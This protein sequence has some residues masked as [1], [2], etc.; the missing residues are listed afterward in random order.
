MLHK[1][2]FVAL[3]CGA[4]CLVGCLKNEESPSVTQVRNAKANELNA[5]AKLLEAQAAAQTTLAAAEAKLKEAQAELAKAN[6]ALVKAQAQYEEV[7]AELLGVEVKLQMVK[8]DEEKVELQ[9]KQA[10][11]EIL[12]AQVEAAK[13]EAEAEVQRWVNELNQLK[14]AAEVQAINAQLQ[15][16]EAQ[17]AM[18]EFMAKAEADKAA[19]MRPYIETYFGICEG[20]VELQKQAINMEIEINNY[21]NG[22]YDVLDGMEEELN[23]LA[24]QYN[25]AQATLEYVSQYQTMTPEEKEAAAAEAYDALNE[26]ITAWAAAT[27]ALDAANEKYNNYTDENASMYVEGWNTAFVDHLEVVE[28][29]GILEGF[30][31]VTEEIYESEEDDYPVEVVGYW[32]LDEEGEPVEFVPLYKEEQWTATPYYYLVDMET[33]MY[34]P[35][36]GYVYDMDKISPAEVYSE[37]LNAVLDQEVEVVKAFIADL[38]DAI[39]EEAEMQKD[40]FE[41]QIAEYDKTLAIDEAYLATRK[42]EVEA[43]E[44][45]LEEALATYSAA[46]KTVNDAWDEYAEYMAITYD[47]RRSYFQNV[48][49]ARENKKEKDLAVVAAEAA[50]KAAEAKVPSEEDIYKADLAAAEKEAAYNKAKKTYDDGGT[51]A[52]LATASEK[53]SIDEDGNESG[54]AVT[55]VKEAEADVAAKQTAY[56]AADIAATA[57]PDDEALQKA[58]ADAKTALDEAIATLTAKNTLLTTAKADYDAAK[59][60]DDTAK[61]PVDDAKA[62]WDEAAEAAQ[63]LHDYVVDPKYQ[64]DFEKAQAD[65]AS[66]N[67]QLKNRENQLANAFAALD[68]EGVKY[69][70]DPKFEELYSAYQTAGEIAGKLGFGSY[71]DEE[72]GDYVYYPCD[73]AYQKVQDLY[74]V[75]QNRDYYSDGMYLLRYYNAAFNVDPT[76]MRVDGIIWNEETQSYE[77]VWWPLNGYL[78]EQVFDEDGNPVYDGDGYEVWEQVLDENGDPVINCNGSASYEKAKLQEAID[79]MPETVE[80]EKALYDA[81]VEEFIEGVDGIRANIAVY[82]GWK[83]AYDTYAADIQEIA[84]EY[85]EALKEYL[86]VYYAFLDAKAAYKAIVGSYDYFYIYEEEWEEYED[87]LGADAYGYNVQLYM[88]Y[89]E[90]ELVEIEAEYNAIVEQYNQTI[91]DANVQL[92]KMYMD[93]DLLLKKIAVLEEIAARYE[94]LIEE[95]FGIDLSPAVE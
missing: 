87:W 27:E 37:N 29:A 43:A 3:L 16:L 33:G 38:K 64:Q 70:D 18:E 66:A 86:D 5:Q 74:W 15:L 44:K 46:E 36:R 4:L 8:V 63:E 26:A 47:I 12:L 51:A 23:D 95:L 82:D 57:N 73:A 90:E 25:Y 77:I 60:A 10:E 88:E 53:Y 92:E 9:K 56:N 94:A 41:E 81:M 48:Y 32:K 20:L 6:A 55:A 69:E 78:Y 54:T 22:I 24:T 76:T 19:E 79:S 28:D 17:K 45:A 61:K 2:Y 52:A 85:N 39:D 31:L 40:L 35:T 91:D 93:Y 72:A 13:A 65:T 80:A 59:K 1:R 84:D 42:P 75:Y 7:R 21:I 50:L 83:P 89:L 11:L 67:A 30:L 49:Y 62:A 68:E 14:A 58:K 71:W 34:N